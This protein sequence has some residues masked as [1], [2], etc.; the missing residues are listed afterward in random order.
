MNEKKLIIYHQDKEYVSRLAGYINRQKRY[1]V[2]AVSFTEEDALEEYLQEN[3]SEILLCEANAADFGRLRLMAQKTFL[4]VEK[5]N[6]A[7]FGD[8]ISRY[9]SAEKILSF[10]AANSEKNSSPEKLG[11]LVG[12]INPGNTAKTDEYAL[13]LAKKLAAK[14]GPGKVLLMC[15]SPLSRMEGKDFEKNQMSELLYKLSFG[16][17]SSLRSFAGQSAGFDCICGFAHWSDADEFSLEKAEGLKELLK[18]GEYEHVVLSFGPLHAF[19][20]PL[21]EAC[22]RIY[23][24]G[25]KD[26]QE[27][28]GLTPYLTE[29]KRQLIF[30]GAEGLVNKFEEVAL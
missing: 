19:F 21:F 17:V 14:S 29:M 22:E 18:M 10:V 8:E 7:G 15:L 4:L 13:E 20:L 27:T 9:V 6:E 28:Q 11:P 24:A 2:T 3:S 12:V 5:E 1:E 26:E 16:E 30:A 25:F 23:L